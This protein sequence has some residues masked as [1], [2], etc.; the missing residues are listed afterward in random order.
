MRRVIFHA[1]EDVS[2]DLF[3]QINFF[4]NTIRV[5]NGLHPDQDRHLV[6]VLILVPENVVRG[7]PTL[8]LVEEGWDDPN[9]T[10]GGPM[11]GHHWPA[12][13]I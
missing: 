11:M 5:S 10:I 12:S 8:F 3:F 1:F 6:V 9:T 4:M 2:A 13:E 7:G